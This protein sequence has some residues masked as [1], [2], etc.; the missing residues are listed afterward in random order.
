MVFHPGMARPENSAPAWP[1]RELRPCAPTREFRPGVAL[2][3]ACVRAAP[4]LPVRLGDLA[5]VAPGA[6]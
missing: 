1:F 3:G 4:V 6:S 2:P 5:L